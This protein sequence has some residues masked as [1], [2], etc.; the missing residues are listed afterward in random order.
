ML[1][2]REDQWVK[3][4]FSHTGFVLTQLEMPEMGRATR[5]MRKRDCMAENKRGFHT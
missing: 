3:K 4:D 1:Y 5:L 2:Y